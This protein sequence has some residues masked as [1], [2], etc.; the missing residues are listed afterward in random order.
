MSGEA[1]GKLKEVEARPVECPEHCGGYAIYNDR[2]HAFSQ[3]L[4]LILIN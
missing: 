1:R 2:Q 4:R 3:M